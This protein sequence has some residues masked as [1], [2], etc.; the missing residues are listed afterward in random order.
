MEQQDYYEILE[1]H[2]KAPPDKLRAAYKRLAFRYHPDHCKDPQATLR[3]QLLNEAYE[4]LSSPE[5]RAQYDIQRENPI[6]EAATEV[7]ITP[8][9]AEQEP[10]VDPGPAVR[11]S[12][13]KRRRWTH[14][15]TAWMRNQ[16]AV[17]AWLLVLVTILFALS[18]F[19]GEFYLV[20]ILVPVL[21]TFFIIVS[22]VVRIKKP[23]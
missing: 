23:A 10:E 15:D 19:T 6:P 2:P 18:L 11:V 13:R 8:E 21:L 20:S 5:K 12:P 7:I 14:E 9:P 1:S 3:M 17:I 4:I 22:I 16:L